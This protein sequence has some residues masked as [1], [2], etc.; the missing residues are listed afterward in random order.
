[1]GCTIFRC[2][3][4]LRLKGDIMESLPQPLPLKA[5]ESIMTDSNVIE[6]LHECLLCRKRWWDVL[7]LSRCQKCGH[8][9]IWFKGTSRLK[10]GNEN[11]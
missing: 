7:K 10:E 3:S 2:K 4:L 5:V 8:Q 11:D 9:H 1:L 6:Y